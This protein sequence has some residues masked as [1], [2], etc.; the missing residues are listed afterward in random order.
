[1]DNEGESIDPRFHF[2]SRFIFTVPDEFDFYSQLQILQERAILFWHLNP[3]INQ[4]NFS[5]AN[6]ILEI[7]KQYEINSYHVPG[8]IFYREGI[9]FI[10]SK[11]GLF[12]NPQTA[13]LLWQL[14]YKKSLK[15]LYGDKQLFPKKSTNLFICDK[16]LWSDG[17]YQWYPYLKT[18]VAGLSWFSLKDIHEFI[19][20]EYILF[21]T[22]V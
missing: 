20:D 1:M 16:G 19:R 5:Q 4:R 14:S 12:I 2:Y 18:Y 21:L 9:E 10:K 11:D 6:N 8:S 15:C 3:S 17:D 13:A 22:E 7:G